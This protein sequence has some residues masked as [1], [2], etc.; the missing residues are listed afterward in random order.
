MLPDNDVRDYLQRLTGLSLLGEVN[1]DK[2][3][4]PIAYGAGANGKT[5]YIETVCFALGDYAMTA[6]PTLLM[7]K[8][9]EVHPTGVADL[10]GKRLVSTTET[11]QGARFDIALLKR[12]TGGDTLKARW[13]RQDFFEFTPSHLLMM[14]T[15]H[16]PEIDDGSEA[17]WRRIRLIPFTVEI[18]KAERD[19]ELGDKL[20]AEA[21][22]VLTWVIDGWADYRKRGLAEPDAVLAATERLP[23]RVR[24]GRP[25][26]RRGM[27]HRRRP[28][29]GHHQRTLQ[30]WE[31]WAAKEG[32]LPM[33]MKAFGRALDVKGFPADKTANR[34][35]RHRICLRPSVS[36]KAQ[37]HEPTARIAR[38]VRRITRATAR[39]KLTTN[40]CYACYRTHSKHHE[41]NR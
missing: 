19:E 8:R 20:R 30:A 13:M 5:T 41:R 26:H 29:I 24:R 16:L 15:N 27:P 4:A 36:R 28:V 39:Q 23:G 1:G 3:I 35:R 14:C 40:A 31:K 37:V 33:S 2:Q 25:V 21:D 11:Q 10:L 22:A 12:L 32:C 38:I 7:S 9:G 34:R 17:V 18:P 6:E